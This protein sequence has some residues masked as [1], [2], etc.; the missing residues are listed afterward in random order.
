MGSP[1]GMRDA[2]MGVEDLGQVRLAL[3]DKLLELGDFA[4]LLEG[5]D[6]I[7]LVPIDCQAG[8]VVSSVLEAR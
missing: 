2:N 6:F 7:L 5:K 1:A 3:L 8:G 4:D